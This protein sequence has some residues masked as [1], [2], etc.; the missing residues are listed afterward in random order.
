MIH[1]EIAAAAL[2]LLLGFLSGCSPQAA[3]EP[4]IGTAFVGPVTL[5]LRKELTLKSPVVATVEHGQ[6]LDILQVRRRFYKVRNEKGIAGWT[7]GTQLLSQADMDAF[8]AASSASANAP[9]QGEAKTFDALNVH[10]EPTRQSPSFYRIPENGKVAVI[11]HRVVPRTKDIKLPPAAPV[12]KLPRPEKKKKES[13]ALP[14]PPM[15]PPPP[16][17]D[18]W[19]EMSRTPLPD[20][21]EAVAEETQATPL[22]PA[23]PSEDDWA[24][25]RTPDGRAG[26]VLFS[27]LFM[28][29]PD[30]V[31]QYAEGH[32][33]TA[34]ASLGEVR[35]G[36][37][38]K[39]HWIW[40]T[41]SK[42]ATP[43]Q[44]DSFRVF[45]WSLKRHRY[46]TAYIERNIKGYYPLSAQLPQ[47]NKL[48]RF[49]VIM[50][51]KEGQIVERVF[52]FNGVRANLVETKPSSKPAETGTPAPVTTQTTAAPG[53]SS[54]WLARAK[55][56]I[57]KLFSQ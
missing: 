41:N 50:E 25:V 43:Y 6:K 3:P 1:R 32:R 55:Q 56:S 29:I 13:K 14:K 40:G 51:N 11:G 42:S 27:R 54:S 5:T 45:I 48:A 9:S 8:R 22:K 46:E 44:F 17:P 10:T 57:S 53:E 4:A 34:Y 28:A 47:G 26:W 31:A 19:L 18:D 12:E 39:H 7:D 37:V 38:V 21:K 33:I 30:D 15:P 2:A 23:K 49:S 35:D 24:L 52:E 16:V 20:P 36:D